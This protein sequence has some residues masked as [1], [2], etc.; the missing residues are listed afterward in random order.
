MMINKM[1]KRT[2]ILISWEALKS[3][4][5]KAWPISSNSSSIDLVVILLKNNDL[6]EFFFKFGQFLGEHLT[7]YYFLEKKIATK[8]AA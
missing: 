3:M 7:E 5:V 8:E 1:G 2:L 4:T 6:L